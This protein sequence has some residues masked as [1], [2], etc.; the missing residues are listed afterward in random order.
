MVVGKSQKIEEKK[1]WQRKSWCKNIPLL[2]HQIDNHDLTARISWIKETC[3]YLSSFLSF[4]F[5][6]QFNKTSLNSSFHE[7]TPNDL[8]LFIHHDVL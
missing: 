2:C 7:G 1:C 3:S 6:I 5:P 8:M 4:K